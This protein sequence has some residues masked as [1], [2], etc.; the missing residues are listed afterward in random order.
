MALLIFG[1]IKICDG[2]VCF[3]TLLNYG[4]VYVSGR[5]RNYQN[6]AKVQWYNSIY[7]LPNQNL[8]M[9]KFGK[10]C[11]GRKVNKPININVLLIFFGL[12][13]HGFYQV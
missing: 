12:I 8:E 6:L 4:G 7:L 11:F 10:V 1:K 13:F 9:L 2:V 3:D 5:S